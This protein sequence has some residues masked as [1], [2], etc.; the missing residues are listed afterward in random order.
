MS[1]VSCRKLRLLVFLG[2]NPHPTGPYC[3]PARPLLVFFINI[4]HSQCTWI[5]KGSII[6]LF[7]SYFQKKVTVKLFLVIHPLIAFFSID[8]KFL[9]RWKEHYATRN[10]NLIIRNICWFICFWCSFFQNLLCAMY[11]KRWFLN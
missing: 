9:L 10:K 1:I 11:V 3:N 5:S 2:V 4:W 7:I 8:W 6:Q